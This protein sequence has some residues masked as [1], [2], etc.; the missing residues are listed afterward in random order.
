MPSAIVN[1]LPVEEYLSKECSAHRVLGQLAPSSANRVHVSHFGVLLK[2]RQPG[3]WRL[4]LDLS[5]TPN[6][7]NDSID[8]DSCS[9][10][11]TTVDDATRLVSQMGQ[12]TLLAKVDIAHAYRN[13]PVHPVDRSLLGMSWK[14][15]V[16]VD[17]TLPFG[18]R[19]APK[20][21]CAISDTLEWVLRQEG[22]TSC[23]HY[24]DDFLTAGSPAA[25]ECRHN[26]T[27]LKTTCERLGIPLVAE[28]IEG[29]TTTLMFLGIE[30]DTQ[31]MCMHLPDEKLAH[32]QQRVVQWQKKRAATKREMLSLIGEL[33]HA[34][35]VVQPGRTF[36]RQM[37]DLAHSRSSLHH[38]IRLNADF[39]SDLMWWHC[40]LERWNGTSSHEARPPS[41]EIFS[42]ASGSW[43]CGALWESYWFQ[44]PWAADWLDINIATKELVPVVIAVGIWGPRWS[45]SQI[46]IH[47]DNMAVVKIIKAR[48]SHD[49][50]IMHL[51]RCLHFLCAMYSIHMLA[52][53]IPGVENIPADA[54]S[55]N[56]LNQFLISTPKADCSA[57]P[58]PWQLWD[59]VVASR[60][61]WMCS[62]WRS[63]LRKL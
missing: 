36:L 46:L 58:V 54:L 7:V 14:G 34:C 32:I 62:S 51:L 30:L 19:S 3:K 33:A 9:L 5:C 11:Y 21:F 61:D 18:L 37:I 43:G 50:L 44:A 47:T 49:K 29:P 28:K 59:L 55:H 45:I 20:I 39:Q 12:G 15:S 41:S 63:K 6:S 17:C 23:L 8:R 35:K 2:R 40:F 52:L 13:V 56:N 42:D 25:S 31:R 10:Q 53:H 4:I 22:I 16:V 26:L 60:P 57:T 1:P 27:V 48:T 38:W 24:I